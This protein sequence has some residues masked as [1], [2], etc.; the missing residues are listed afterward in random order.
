MNHGCGGSHVESLRAAKAA[1]MYS[2]NQTVGKEKVKNEGAS[3][4]GDVATMSL[5]DGDAKKT[6][7]H[8]VVFRRSNP[9]RGVATR[10]SCQLSLIHQRGKQTLA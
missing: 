1:V 6:A 3:V 7:E 2:E 4:W 8:C 5:A 10:D 9:G